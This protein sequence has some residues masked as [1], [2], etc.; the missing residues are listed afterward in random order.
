MT[1]RNTS[2]IYAITTDSYIARFT[3]ELVKQAQSTIQ[4]HPYAAVLFQGEKLLTQRS[5]GS[6]VAL[7]ALTL[8]E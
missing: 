8:T 1:E 7:N 5:N 3:M 4:V 2:T 6:A